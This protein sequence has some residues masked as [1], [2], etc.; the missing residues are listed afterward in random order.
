MS[1]NVLN[2]PGLMDPSTEFGSMMQHAMKIKS[3]QMDQDRKKFETYP[4]FLQ[5][6]M[7]MQNDECLRLREVPVA[8][9]LPEAAKLKE[10]G[11]EAFRKQAFAAAVESYEA[12]LGAFKYAK[13]LDP[14]WKKKGIK[15]ETIEWH[16][17]MGE[18]EAERKAVCRS[19][20]CHAWPE[21]PQEQ[22]S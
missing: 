19:S 22:K 10:A 16:D 6:T 4:M 15:D 7:W 8:E 17:D 9:R 20:R 14:D 11:N 12:A 1:D 5:N 21:K 18:S 3:H 2:T 13:Q